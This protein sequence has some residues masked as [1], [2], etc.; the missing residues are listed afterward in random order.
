MP[1]QKQQQSKAQ[2]PQSAAHTILVERIG[3]KGSVSVAEFM[4]IAVAHYYAAQ[5]PF[6]D[7]GDFTTA[8]EI[9]QMFGEMLGAWLVDAWMQAGKPEKAHL[10][11]LGP[12]RGTL[13][14][15]VL[16]TVSNWPECL[17]SMDLHLV[18]TSPLLRARQA[19]ELGEYNPTWHDDISTLPEGPAFILANEFFDALPI[20]QFEMKGGKWH[21]RHVGYDEENETFFF[22]LKPTDEPEMPEAKDGGIFEK[23][24]ASIA[25]A[26]EICKILAEQG[27][28]ALFVDYGHAMSGIG[29][30]LQAVKDHKFAEVLENPGRNDIT[31]HVDFAALKRAAA[32]KLRVHG[33]VEQGAFL[34]R[35][36]IS[37]RADALRQKATEEQRKNIDAALFRL[38]AATE[39]GKLFKV[40]ALTPTG[41]AIAPAGFD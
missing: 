1:E 9:S 20:Q 7:D 5:D 4:E 33:P 13:A 27:G 40:L 17:A 35:L 8:P 2:E 21:E 23:S 32:K 6:G 34:L 19:D 28:A 25:V 3:M 39:M 37:T 10:V 16:R 41:S 14:S 12:G 18:E 29:D 11:E 24:P 31:A 15:D 36:G 38:T 26:G 22:T 30:T